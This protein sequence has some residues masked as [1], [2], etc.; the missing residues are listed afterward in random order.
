M[1]RLAQGLMS[2]QIGS[3]PG[4]AGNT[5]RNHIQQLLRLFDVRTRTACVASARL[6]DLVDR[7][8]RR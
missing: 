5:V 4:I 1:A 3:H 8:A 7:S 2:T 6:H